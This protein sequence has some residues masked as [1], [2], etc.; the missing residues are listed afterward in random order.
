MG[1]YANCNTS[2]VGLTANDGTRLNRFT[3]FVPKR[4]ETDPWNRQH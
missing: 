1:R 3:A 4:K 2:I